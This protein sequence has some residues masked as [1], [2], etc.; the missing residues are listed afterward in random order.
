MEAVVPVTGRTAE[1]AKVKLPRSPIASK[2]VSELRSNEAPPKAQQAPKPDPKFRPKVEKSP[3]TVDRG[4]PSPT[5]RKVESETKSTPERLQPAGHDKP[6]QPEAQPRTKD[7]QPKP[8]EQT[9]QDGNS[10]DKKAQPQSERRAKGAAVKVQ[11][12]SQRNARGLEKK[13]PLQSEPRPPVPAVK[14]HDD[15]QQRNAGVVEKKPQRV[16][17]QPVRQRPNA[18]EKGAVQLLKKDRQEKDDRSDAAPDNQGH[19][20]K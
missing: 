3:P 11:E 17:E 14:P 19:Q 6:N 20:R 18:G 8:Q 9:P 13:A 4:N 2:P 7:A 1:P 10:P 5:P 12:E 16:P 15:S